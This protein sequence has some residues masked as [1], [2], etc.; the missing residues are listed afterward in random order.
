MTWDGT[1][2]L[3]YASWGG[4]SIEDAPI[5]AGR[6]MLDGTLR[7]DLIAVKAKVKID[8]R[9]LTSG[10]RGTLKGIFD[11]GQSGTL[12]LP[13]TQTWTVVPMPDSWQEEIWNNVG[14]SAYYNVSMTFSEV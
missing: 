12:A 2:S 13:D 8:W 7:T 14:G 4:I 10:S 11:A 5:A 9:A 1:V 6:R 3:P